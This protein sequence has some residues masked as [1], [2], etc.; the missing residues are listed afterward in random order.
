MLSM[1]TTLEK[2]ST[3]AILTMMVE[4]LR[5]GITVRQKRCTKPTKRL[6]RVRMPAKDQSSWLL[7]TETRGGSGI[8]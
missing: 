6:C 5:N 2:A 4:R 3:Q 7:L 1:P 8:L